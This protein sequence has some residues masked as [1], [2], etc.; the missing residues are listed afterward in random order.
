MGMTSINLGFIQN[1]IRMKKISFSI[2]LISFLFFC[3]KKESTHVIRKTTGKVNNISVIID[4]QQWN[5]EIGDS[6]RNKF[7]SPVIGLPQEEPLFTINQYPLKLMEGFMTD[8]RNIIIVKKGKKNNFVIKKDQYAAPQNVFHISGNTSDDILSIF[9]KNSPQI[10]EI[11]RQTEIEECQRIN[12]KVLLD[13]RIITNKFHITLDVP[14]DYEYMVQESDFIWLKKEL[15][16]G[17]T[18]LLLYQ[19]PINAIKNK[20]NLVSNIIKMRDSVGALYIHGKEPNTDMITEEAYSPYF[21]KIKLDGKVAY[22]MKG[23]WEL[24]N[25]F[26]SGPFINYAILDKENDRVLFL[27]GFCYSPSKEKR[28]LMHQLESIIKSVSIL[29]K[30]L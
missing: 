4:D 6:I 21:F 23:T 19:V 1:I 24:R 5:G 14:S 8:S 9:E 28:D 13:P 22:E 27:E 26:M 3:C 25:D 2:L 10:I 20:D 7:A 29:K 18:S 11:I 16:S 30:E 15:V 17:N 12:K